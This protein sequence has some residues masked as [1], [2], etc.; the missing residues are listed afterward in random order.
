MGWKLV[1][2]TF[3]VAPLIALLPGVAL[4]VLR[5][6]HV[7][8]Y[9]PFLSLGLVLALFAG[10]V[11]LRASGVEESVRLLWFYTMPWAS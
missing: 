3:F 9:G 6:S 1:T 2:F 8:P 5:R 10:E 7:I 11:F 4:L